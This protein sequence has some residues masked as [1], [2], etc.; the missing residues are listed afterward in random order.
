MLQQ[1]KAFVLFPLPGRYT[2]RSVKKLM[3]SI[4]TQ[5]QKLMSYICSPICFI[6]QN[7]AF[8]VHKTLRWALCHWLFHTVCHLHS[9]FPLRLIDVECV[10]NLLT[11]RYLYSNSSN[12]IDSH[13]L[14]MYWNCFTNFALLYVFCTLYYTFIY[15][16][17]MPQQLHL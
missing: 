2:C 9:L 17:V 3:Y 16:L 1:I 6:R 7:F 13:L 11:S 5:I 4:P 15:L 12:A 14:L 8:Y 10:N